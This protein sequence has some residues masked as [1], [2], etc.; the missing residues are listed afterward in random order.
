M[1]WLNYKPTQPLESWIV[2]RRLDSHELAPYISQQKACPIWLVHKD[3]KQLSFPFE[4]DA[5]PSSQE[6]M[7]SGDIDITIELKG[8]IA[9]YS[10]TNVH[11]QKEIRNKLREIM[12]PTSTGTKEPLLPTKLKGRPKGSTKKFM[13]EYKNTKCNPSLFEHILKEDIS[14]QRKL[15][16][17]SRF[18]SMRS[19]RLYDSVRR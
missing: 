2:L 4:C 9:R 16:K 10:N 13:N 14:T 12:D 3:W 17:S 11:Q 8:I 1:K 19:N 5:M 15:S 7:K 6:S 18:Q